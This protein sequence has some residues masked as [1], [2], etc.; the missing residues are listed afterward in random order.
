M[1]GTA[2]SVIFECKDTGLSPEYTTEYGAYPLRVNGGCIGMA[3][4]IRSIQNTETPFSYDTEERF[5]VIGTRFI[6][7]LK[8]LTIQKT[9][10]DLLHNAGYDFSIAPFKLQR[11]DSAS[12]QWKLLMI[13]C[14]IM[15]ATFLV[16]LE[17]NKH[18]KFEDPI[19]RGTV[20]AFRTAHVTKNDRRYVQV[21]PI[22]E[23]TDSPSSHVE[24]L[25]LSI[26]S[27][28]SFPALKFTAPAVI[29]DPADDFVCPIC[30]DGPETYT[31]IVDGEEVVRK[32]KIFRTGCGT[33]QGH[34][35]HRQCIE[36]W[37]SRQT[38]T[39]SIGKKPSCPV[40]QTTIVHFL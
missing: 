14:Q 36:E 2:C 16:Y 18:S 19:H 23:Q 28:V 31:E 6:N 1:E 5:K 35:F 12:N 25:R 11:W 27:D 33:D 30:F 38:P 37:F 32:E 15:A 3:N 29:A 40:C 7:Q 9:F 4:F 21:T 13:D 22:L 17:K 34:C 24:G 8:H 39:P 10:H 26:K 20:M